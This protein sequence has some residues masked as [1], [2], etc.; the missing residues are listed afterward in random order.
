MHHRTLKQQGSILSYTHGERARIE[1][2]S[3]Y[4]R[5]SYFFW[6]ECDVDQ[7]SGL[8]VIQLMIVHHNKVR[9]KNVVPRLHHVRKNPIWRNDAR[10]KIAVNEFENLTDQ[11]LPSNDLL[12]TLYN[13]YD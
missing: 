2:Q 8:F 5:Y 11:V 1:N 9:R 3:S 10:K 6:K 13:K 4:H 7:N 12:N